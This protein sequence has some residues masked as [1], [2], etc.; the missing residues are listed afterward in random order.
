MGHPRAAYHAPASAAA[1]ATATTTNPAATFPRARVGRGRRR[2]TSG[3]GWGGG[4]FPQA[5]GNERVPQALG[6]CSNGSARAVG[7][8]RQQRLEFLVAGGREHVQHLPQVA[9]AAL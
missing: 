6:R 1:A 5:Y 8:G 9:P 4:C 7:R 3:S 2:W